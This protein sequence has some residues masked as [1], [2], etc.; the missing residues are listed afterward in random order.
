LA[1]RR[2]FPA[3]WLGGPPDQPATD[4]DLVVLLV[5]SVDLLEAEPDRLRD[6]GWLRTALGQAGHG[7]VAAG[8]RQRDAARLRRLRDE[9]RVVFETDDEGAAAGRLNELL[10]RADAIP[11]LAPDGAG[12]RLAVAPGRTGFAALAARLP[13]ALAAHVAQHGLRRLGVCGSDP[14]RCAF[15]DRTR[16]ATRRYC[17]GW[18]NDRRAARAYR[19]RQSYAGGA[20]NSRAMLSGSRKDTPEP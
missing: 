4:L 20:K 6:I 2:V 11:L 1:E 10:R 7:A 3:E 15:V 13:A 17:C 18:C 5:N 14:C 9:L 19:R 8:L 12:W 16:G